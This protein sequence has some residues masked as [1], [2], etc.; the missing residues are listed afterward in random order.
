MSKI[1]LKKINDPRGQ[2]WLVIDYLHPC[3]KNSEF[4]QDYNYQIVAH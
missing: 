2:V 1:F 3:P 4:I